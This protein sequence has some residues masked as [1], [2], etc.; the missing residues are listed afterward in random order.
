MKKLLLLP[1]FAILFLMPSCSSDDD[2]TPP[3]AGT[4][5]FG[6]VQ[7][8]APGAT[9]GF[10][11]ENVETEVVVNS[12][13][14]ALTLTIYDV[15]F[16]EAMP[17]TYD[18]TLQ[19]IPCVVT[20]DAVVFENNDDIIPLVGTTSSPDFIFSKV[21]GCIDRAGNISFNAE[22]IRGTFTYTGTASN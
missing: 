9:E 14:T 12:E 16:A 3:P 15:K 7:A 8:Y 2:K 13:R 21:E 1:L 11:M 19:D 18:I 17:I 6:T 20:E 10:I 4:T 5:N 22:M